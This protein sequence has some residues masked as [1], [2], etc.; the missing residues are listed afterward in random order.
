MCAATELL[1]P[2]FH[3]VARQVL[4]VADASQQPDDEE[5]AVVSRV[6]YGEV[7]AGYREVVRA[8]A[9]ISG[10]EYGVFVFGSAFEKG[11]GR[12]LG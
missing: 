12:F 4:A 7:P 9:L 10:E 5:N 2:K 3:D 11:G 6:V 8:P 1:S